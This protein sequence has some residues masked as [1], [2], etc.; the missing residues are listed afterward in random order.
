MRKW[1]K[2]SAAKGLLIV[3]VCV[4]MSFVSFSVACLLSFKNNVTGTDLLS[5]GNKSYADTNT[6]ANTTH[7]AAYTVLAQLRYARNLETDGTYDENRLVDLKEYTDTGTVSGENTSGLAYTVKD[8]LEWASTGV[9]VYSDYDDAESYVVCQKPDGTYYYYEIAEFTQLMESRKL[10][11]ETA[12][13]QASADSEESGTAVEATEET[14][15]INYME[16]FLAD[17]AAGYYN[18]AGDQ[19]DYA[20]NQNILDEKGAVVYTASWTYDFYLKESYPPDGAKS[21]LDVVNH[22]PE[23]NGKLSEIENNLNNMIFSIETE[24]AQ[25]QYPSESYSEGNTNLAYIIFDKTNK[26]V[27]TNRKGYENYEK[28]EENIKTMMASGAYVKV[29][30]DLEGFETSMK[31]T[32]VN[33]STLKEQLKYTLGSESFEYV[34]SVDTDY[35]IQDT[36][37]SANQEYQR[38]APYYRI[39]IVLSIVSIG[40]FIMAIIWLTVIAGRNS[41]NDALHLNAFDRIWTEIAGLLVVLCWG[42]PVSVIANFGYFGYYG[43]LSDAEYSIMYTNIIVAFIVTIFTVV[44]FL[45]G[46]MSLVRRIKAGTLWRNSLVRLLLHWFVRVLRSLHAG[47]REFWKN[48]KQTFKLVVIVFFVCVL[49]WI[50]IAVQGGFTLLVLAVEAA[51]FLYLMRRA[52]AR[53]KIKTAIKEIASGNVDYKVPLERLRGNDLEVAVL[54]NNIG[55]G[56]MAA[57]EKNMK[58]ERMKTDLITNVSHDIKTPLT[59]IINYIDLLKR[60]NFTD[61]KIV[62]YIEV[63]ENKAQQLKH[64]TEDVVEASKVSSG[65]ITLEC[66]DINLVEM[67]NQIDGEYEEKLESRHLQVIKSIPEESVVI[68]AD[69][70]RMS[71]ILDNIYGNAWKYAMEGTRIY[72]G[73]AVI[74]GQAEFS[75]KN[76]SA[77]PLNI[78]A[79]ELTERFIRGDVARTTEGS[80]LGLSIAKSLAELQGGTFNLYLDGDLFKATVVFPIVSRQSE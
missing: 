41:K 6:F 65:N 3:M 18:S 30:P 39:M 2:S 37:Y 40:L 32:A 49:H 73:L 54:I 62:G 27:Y 75:L 50:A 67:I 15:Y 60:E 26:K 5:K 45:I 13:S 61:P 57:V 36:Y 63:L 78:T 53:D 7:E 4:T 43:A 69:G 31:T 80:G 68:H 71:R 58:D 44:M 28:A 35:P 77:Q 33:W 14:S 23:W 64:L 29:T 55:G 24:V 51:V 20:W 70:R 56:L 17:L 59:S 25:Y 19:S 12:A 11:L 42:F 8:L 74:N 52:I 46:W 22:N 72:A 38:F 10:T 76:I 9:T 21:I 66:M 1:Y 79:E 48:R 47:F 34:I 16:S